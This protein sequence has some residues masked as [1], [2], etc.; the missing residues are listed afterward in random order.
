MK[1]HVNQE[2]LI[3]ILGRSIS[4]RSPPKLNLYLRGNQTINI[5]DSY[6]GMLQEDTF[7]PY[8]YYGSQVY[9]NVTSPGPSTAHFVHPYVHTST[10]LP[11]TSQSS[12]TEDSTEREDDSR[13]RGKVPKKQAAK[14]DSFEPEEERYLVNLWERL[15]SKDARKYWS[16]IVDELNAN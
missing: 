4:V 12:Q 15:E 9:V 2:N 16:K 3:S 1:E 10:S 5:D 6:L 8:N 13:K 7:A 14:Y 11:S